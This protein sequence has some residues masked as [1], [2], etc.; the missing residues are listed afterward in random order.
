MTRRS[1]RVD[2]AVRF[3]TDP[4]TAARVMLDIRRVLAGFLSTSE[5]DDAL[6]VQL[7]SDQED[8]T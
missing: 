1:W 6:D 7:H 8:P 2:A 3:K 5:T 4:Q